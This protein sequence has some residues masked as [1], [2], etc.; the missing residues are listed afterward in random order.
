MNEYKVIYLPFM[1]YIMI[2]IYYDKHE[3]G[4]KMAFNEYFSFLIQ[5]K[6]SQ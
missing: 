4:N 5:L 2:S 6:L 1:S 3:V